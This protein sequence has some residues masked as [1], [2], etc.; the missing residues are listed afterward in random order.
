MTYNSTFLSCC[1]GALQKTVSLSPHKLFFNKL[2]Y[3]FCNKLKKLRYVRIVC[4]SQGHKKSAK[5]EISPT[6]SE[7]HLSASQQGPFLLHLL[8]IH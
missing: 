1:I 2:Q 6:F 4:L 7:S 8:E 5:L 3:Y